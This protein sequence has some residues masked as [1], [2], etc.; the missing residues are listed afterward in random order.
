[1]QP[2]QAHAAEVWAVVAYIYIRC[3][4]RPGQRRRA[5]CLCCQEIRDLQL[6]DAT[7]TKN[8]R[9]DGYSE[10]RLFQTF[11][12]FVGEGGRPTTAFHKLLAPSRGCD[13]YLIIACS[14]RRQPNAHWS[15]RHGEQQQQ[16]R[17]AT[18]AEAFFMDRDR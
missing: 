15:Y 3:G 18:R 1:M 2:W 13:A 17:R 10:H 16:R 8:R 6:G 11:F 12:V 9:R 7:V 14:W 5:W 4:R